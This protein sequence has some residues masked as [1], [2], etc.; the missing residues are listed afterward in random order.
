MEGAGN[1]TFTITYP[2]SATLA[3]FTCAIIFIIFGVIGNLITA[4]A[5]LRCPKLRG[6]ATTTF[7]LSLCVSDLLFCSINLPLT[8]SRYLYQRWILGDV[9]CQLFPVIFYGN[10]AVSLLSMVAITLNRYVLIA[11]YDLYGR[12]YSKRNIYIQLTFIWIFAFGLMVP[13][14]FGI[15]G[16]LGLDEETFSCTILKKDEFSPKKFLFLV[17][18]VLPCLVITISYSCIYWKVRGSKRRLEAHS[19]LSVKDTGVSSRERDDS[20]LTTLMLSIFLCFVICFLPL[21]MTNV[22]DDDISF[23]TFHVVASIL[24]WASS[25]INPFIYAATNRQYRSAYKKLFKSCRKKP[26]TRR[27]TIGSK[28]FCQPTSNHSGN[29][30]NDKRMPVK[31]NSNT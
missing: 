25:V 3:A 18:F 24:A 23:P 31:L 13:P 16:Q 6:H 4:L 7:V 15:W 26:I 21:M 14:L 2:R 20:R 30:H 9:L 17:A 5:L 29:S 12:L 19:E 8:A 11:Y 22:I 10:V 27:T 28:T 1:V